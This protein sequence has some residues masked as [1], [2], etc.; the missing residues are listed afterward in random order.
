M[1]ANR[2]SARTKNQ[3]TKGLS[4]KAEKNTNLSLED[5]KGGIFRTVKCSNASF[6][7]GIKL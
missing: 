4:R 2:K 5:W 7:F 6:A 1:Q 3:K